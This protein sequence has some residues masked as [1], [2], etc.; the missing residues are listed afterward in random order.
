MNP[1]RNDPCPCGSGK[2]YKACCQPRDRA[3]AQARATM[4][5]EAFDESEARVAEAARRAPRW[6]ADVVPL[7]I[8]LREDRDAAPGLAMVTA[9]G[10]V[11][12]ADT[13]AQR[14]IGLAARAEAVVRA[15]SGAARVAGVFPETLRVR[16]GAVA[17][18]VQEALARR[19]VGVETGAIPELDEALD[20]ALS[21]LG[22]GPQAAAAAMP[23]SWRETEASDAEL[24]ALHAAAAAYHRAAPWQGMGDAESLLLWFPGEEEPWAA[25]VMGGAGVTRGLA[26]YSD[27][28]DVE[29]ILSAAITRSADVLLEFRGMSFSLT[30]DAASD[31]PRQM[32]R[33]VAAAHWEVAAA[34]AHPTLMA[35]RAPERRVTPDHVRRITAAL[36]AVTAAAALPLGEDPWTDPETGIRL[37]WMYGDEEE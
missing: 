2:K 33:E 10:Y 14:P 3:R 8:R 24:A 35:L 28:D 11:L 13:L 25:S 31:L 26:I 6:E 17:A 4:G 36:R 30:F 20:S 15:V 12:H 22:G 34:D 5:D 19:G 9:A 27:P 21:H 16:E 18:A 32:R 1:S 29:G 37:A 23:L 7:A